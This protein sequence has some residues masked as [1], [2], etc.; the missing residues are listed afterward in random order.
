MELVYA[1][2]LPREE[3]SV[4][5]VRHLCKSTLGDLGVSRACSDDIELAVTEACS[6][7][8]RHAGGQGEYEVVIR[9]DG[10]VC[11][12]EVR[13]KGDGFDHEKKTTDWLVTIPESGRGIH[14]MKA[15]VDELKFASLQEGT[16][17][18]LTKSLELEPSSLLGVVART[19][20]R[21]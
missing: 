1:L 4:P 5:F 6:N 17:V 20:D 14:L 13:D 19:P 8:L 2:C 3:A 7:V 15:L 11:T 21:A 12:I 18:T 9:I 10:A 16:A